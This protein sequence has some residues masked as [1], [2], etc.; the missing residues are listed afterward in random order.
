MYFLQKVV[1]RR[2]EK[3]IPLMSTCI[4]NEHK[5]NKVKRS[6]GAQEPTSYARFESW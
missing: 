6:N 4:Y 3:K 1:R 5:K 2:T